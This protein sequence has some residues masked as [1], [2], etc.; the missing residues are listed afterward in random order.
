M[1]KPLIRCVVLRK[2]LPSCLSMPVL[3][4]VFEVDAINRR[5]TLMQ[6]RWLRSTAIVKTPTCDIVVLNEAPIAVLAY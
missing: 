1:L 2:A 6:T 5:P 3:C 4:D